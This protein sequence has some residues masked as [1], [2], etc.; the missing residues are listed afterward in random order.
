MKGELIDESQA[1]EMDDAS[2]SRKHQRH[3]NTRLVSVHSNRGGNWNR[4]Y[5]RDHCAQAS[6][7]S[8]DHR[9]TARRH[10]PEDQTDNPLTLPL[11]EILTFGLLQAL[12]VNNREKASIGQRLREWRQHVI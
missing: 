2:G 1:A 7:V 8:A 4:H 9:F 3:R 5:Y 10:L 6:G 11:C 12:Y